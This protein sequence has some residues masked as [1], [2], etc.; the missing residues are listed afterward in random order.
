MLICATINRL[1]S[2]AGE[3][4]IDTS[5]LAMHSKRCLKNDGLGN[6]QFHF[7][8]STGGDNTLFNIDSKTGDITSKAALDSGAATDTAVTGSTAGDTFMILK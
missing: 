8:R 4:S 7:N 5:F 3:V 2:E 1:R 6:F